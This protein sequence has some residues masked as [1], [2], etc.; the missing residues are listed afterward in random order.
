MIRRVNSKSDYLYP[1]FGKE[2]EVGKRAGSLLQP[3]KQEMVLAELWMEQ[4]LGLSPGHLSSS[5]SAPALYPPAKLAILGRLPEV[6][7]DL[8]QNRLICF[9]LFSDMWDHM[10]LPLTT[11][12]FT[13]RAQHRRIHLAAEMLFCEGNP[14]STLCFFITAK[15]H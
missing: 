13:A 9:S 10:Y 7:Q 15:E 2:R 6:G 5:F 14:A 1:P 3:A 4:K 12:W 11:W 8:L